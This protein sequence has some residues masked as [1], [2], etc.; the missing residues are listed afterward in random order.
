M[1][2]RVALHRVRN[3]VHSVR[4]IVLLHNHGM[5]CTHVLYPHVHALL[6]CAHMTRICFTKLTIIDTY[7][8]RYRL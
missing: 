4:S 3:I 5:T 2:W 1:H 7:L 8:N 6:S